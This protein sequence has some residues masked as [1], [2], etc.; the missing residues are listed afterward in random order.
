MYSID[1]SNNL[2]LSISNRNHMIINQKIIDEL[3]KDELISFPEGTKII[4]RFTDINNFNILLENNILLKIY[5]WPIKCSFIDYNLNI[6]IYSYEHLKLI[7]SKLD[8]KKPYFYSEFFLKYIYIDTKNKEDK[9]IGLDISIEMRDKENYQKEIDNIYEKFKKIYINNKNIDKNKY[10]YEYI[11]PNYNIYFSESDNAQKNLSKEFNY[12]NTFNRNYLLNKIQL[13]LKNKNDFN[14][15]NQTFQSLNE[16]IKED[17]ATLFPICCPQGTGKTITALYIHKYLF[18]KGMKGIYLNIEFLFNNKIIWENKLDALIKECF[19]ICENKDDLIELY[20]N[21]EP[22]KKYSDIITIIKRFI[23]KKD[24]NIYIILDHYQNRYNLQSV[25]NELINIKIFLISSINDQDVKLNLIKKYKEEINIKIINKIE[26]ENNRYKGARDIIRYNYIENLIEEEYYNEDIYKNIIENKIKSD[27]N[28]NMNENIN[29]IYNIL[30]KFNLIP[31]YTFEYINDF[32]SIYDFLFYEY[33]NI[34]N[35]LYMLDKDSII[36]ADKLIE[37]KNNKYLKLKNSNEKKALNKIDFIKYLE[38]IPLQYINFSKLNNGDFYFHYAFPLFEIILNDFFDYLFYKKKFLIIK[39]EK[40]RDILF[41]RILKI[42]F[43]AF[44]HFNVD[45]YFA[46]ND[47]IKMDLITDYNMINKEYFK[48]KH[49]I[50]IEQKDEK[51]NFYDFAIYNSLTKELI[52]LQSKYIINKET[53]IKN[54]D[55]YVESANN[56]LLAFNK[57]SKEDAK[58][59]HL[60]LL[61][62]EEYNFSNKESIFNILYKNKINCI[63][64]SVLKDE[65]SD[66]FKNIIKKITCSKS[67]MLIPINEF[68]EPLIDIEKFEFIEN[69]NKDKETYFLNF[70]TKRDN[71]TEFYNEIIKFILNSKFEHKNIIQSLGKLKKMNYISK[72][73]L[74]KINVKNEY[75]LFFYLDIYGKFDSS[76]NLGLLY[77]EKSKNDNYDLYAYNIKENYTFNSFDELM[78]K[79]DFNVFYAIVERL[80]IKKKNN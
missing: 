69:D 24:K 77:F 13:F 49:N 31:K 64:Y 61:S 45:G 33:S 30:K 11:C 34:F 10:T 28:E 79:F 18:L 51:G 44:N 62:S 15:S 7:L 27:K 42:N 57:I 38:Y 72:N 56:A 76:K 46:V 23:E 68:Y 36:N 25:L 3:S 66:D 52:L 37:L 20:K 78:N 12:I 53:I 2:F 22:L 8:Y 50:F 74:E 75:A 9:R 80:I 71:L 29:Q 39:D 40:E 65:Y 55:F 21:L 26:K 67:S 59:V 19:F 70:K 48:L 54:K 73:K 14:S 16:D 63:F 41:K 43:K 32:E 35:E 1:Q 47:L 58:Y 4:N 6:I 17:D 60:F 5:K